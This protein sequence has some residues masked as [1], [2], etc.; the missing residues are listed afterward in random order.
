MLKVLRITEDK[1]MLGDPNTKQLMTV[2]LGDCFEGIKIGDYVDVYASDDMVFVTRFEEHSSESQIETIDENRH[3]QLKASEAEITQEH[4]VQSDEKEI[5]SHIQQSTNDEVQ[6]HQT[7]KKEKTKL[8][9]RFVPL[10]FVIVLGV[11]LSFFVGS[12]LDFQQPK[13]YLTSFALVNEYI[14]QYRDEGIFVAEY[15][16][17][18]FYEVPTDLREPGSPVLMMIGEMRLIQYDTESTSMDLLIL[19]HFISFD[20]ID[21]CQFSTKDGE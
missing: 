10:V 21:Y 20:E 4:V 14:K 11:V 2:N 16:D 5:K 3:E 6:T 15:D 17:F 8:K 12:F 7:A 1:V 13:P 19:C 9:L 18:S